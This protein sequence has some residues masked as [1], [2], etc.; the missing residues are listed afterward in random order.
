MLH[1][2]K[3]FLRGASEVYNV[4]LGTLSR[5]LAAFKDSGEE[6]AHYSR[7]NAVK[8]LLMQKKRNP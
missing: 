7:N 2:V 3:E 5:R 8:Q 6:Y 4:S 1:P